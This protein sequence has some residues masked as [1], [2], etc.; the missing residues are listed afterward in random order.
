MKIKGFKC[1]GNGPKAGHS[2]KATSGFTGSTGGTR[3]V[4]GYTQSVPK[5]RFAEGGRVD[6]SVILRDKP[7]TQFDRE[8]GGKTPLAPGFKKGGWIDKAIKHP[9]AL[10]KALDVPAGDKIPA[11]KLKK[12]AHSKNPTMRKR[13]QLAETLKG[14]NK[15]EG[16]AVKK[17]FADGGK[18]A[19]V[20]AAIRM[21]KE[22]I[23]RGEAHEAAA[24][25][26]AT[27]YGVDASAVRQ[28]AQAMS[29]PTGND[30]QMLARGGRPM[31]AMGGALNTL[32]GRAPPVRVQMGPSAPPVRTPV[33]QPGPAAPGGGYGAF[34][35]GPL[36]R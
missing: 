21:M 34:R 4:R 20:G 25:K 35:R 9:G 11:K 16:G 32:A 13:A 33:L 30:P 14:F 15:A 19:T 1:T 10:H 18:V 28:E 8:H 22:L 6:S 23:K 12:A 29:P 3:Q 5:A 2:F 17:N 26:A 31:P 27:R 7:V 36:V 24:R